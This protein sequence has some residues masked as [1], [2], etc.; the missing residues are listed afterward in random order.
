MSLKIA[1]VTNADFAF[2]SHRIPY[3]Q[4]A[5]EM[6]FSVVVIA[7]ENGFGHKIKNLGFEFIPISKKKDAIPSGICSELFL[8]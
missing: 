2:L 6:G 4:A 1:F 8:N 5:Q 7:P 3:A